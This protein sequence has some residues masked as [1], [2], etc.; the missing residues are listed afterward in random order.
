MPPR[1]KYLKQKY[2]TFRKGGVFGGGGLSWSPL[3]P[4]RSAPIFYI[5]DIASGICYKPWQLHTVVVFHSL[6][7][8]AHALKDITG[9]GGTTPVNSDNGR[10]FYP[11]INSTSG[12]GDRRS[13]A[14]GS[15]KSNIGG[16]SRR[17]PAARVVGG[18]CRDKAGNTARSSP[19]AKRCNRKR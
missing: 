9:S 11:W 16:I 6:T 5:K 7:C 10:S 13:R 3:D 14:D 4:T 1:W 12:S 18:S 19:C 8:D 15:R 17:L 2:E